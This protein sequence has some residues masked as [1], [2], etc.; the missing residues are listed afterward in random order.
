MATRAIAAPGPDL[1]QVLTRIERAKLEA[2][3]EVTIGILNVLDGDAE[4]EPDVDRCEADDDHPGP[5]HPRWKGVK[6]VSL[7]DDHGRCLIYGVDQ[8]RSIADEVMAA[9]SLAAG[10]ILWRATL[11][12]FDAAGW[13]RG[14]EQAG[15]SYALDADGKLSLFTIQPDARVAHHVAQVAGRADRIGAVVALLQ[16]ARH[17]P[18][19]AA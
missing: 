2:F 15:G 10:Q 4:A 13:L 18:R 9:R 17:S 11:G 16:E 5:I 8:R 12:T 3:V 14:F 1:V 6:P 7:D 19:A